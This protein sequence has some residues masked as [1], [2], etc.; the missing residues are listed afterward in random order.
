MTI[1]TTTGTTAQPGAEELAAELAAAAHTRVGVE[2]LSA[3]FPGLTLDTAY[4]VQ[5]AG[6]RAR[7]AAGDRVVGHKVGLTSDV[8][9]ATSESPALAVPVLGRRSP[10]PRARSRRRRG[11]TSPPSAASPST[12]WRRGRPH[13]PPSSCTTDGHLDR[14]TWDA[15]LRAAAQVGLPGLL[16]PEQHGGAGRSC[17]DN[18][19]VQE[20]LGAVDAGVAGALSL[21]MSV[22]SMLLAAGGPEQLARWVPRLLAEAPLVLAGALSES[23]VAGSDL[24]DPM[25]DPSHGI[26]TWATRDGDGWIISGEK[27]GW[28]TNGGLA[29]VYLVF[30]RTSSDGPAAT[31]TTAFW[32]EADA[33]G[34]S[35]GARSELLGL[36]SAAHAPVHLDAVR[37][38]DSDRIGGV[39]Q[40]LVLMQTT[41]P[42]MAVGLAATFVGVAR[43]AL[44]VALDWSQQRRSWGQSIA[45]T[46]RS[47]CGWPRC[48]WTWK[49]PACWC[50]RRPAASTRSTSPACRCSSR[51]A[52]SGPWTSPSRAP[53]PACRCWGP[54]ASPA[55]AVPRSCSAMPGRAGRATSPATCSVSRWPRGSAARR[56]AA[57]TVRTG[58]H[59]GRSRI[60]RTSGATK[61]RS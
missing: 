24:F 43:A 59:A 1:T 44:D 27:S 7:L 5:L 16:L 31:T 12:C 32:V 52:R 19:L 51:G 50:T 56:G 21:T 38:P 8:T 2:P 26:R 46:R 3:R 60:A 40:G 54:P 42:G 20:E 18:A 9:A 15:L 30:A 17:L 41:T 25:A 39:G 55:A 36:R 28:V 53:R 49:P 23:D 4:A 37:V 33:P 45:A 58:R 22:P 10:A 14:P 57:L 48:A 47:P 34:L 35:V 6:V 11:A 61:R 29:G 13:G